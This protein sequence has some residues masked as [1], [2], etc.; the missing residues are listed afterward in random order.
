[1]SVQS[2][3]LIESNQTI[4]SLESAPSLTSFSIDEIFI[5]LSQCDGLVG[6]SLDRASLVARIE[7]S[8]RQHLLSLPSPWRSRV[9][10][11]SCLHFGA[12]RTFVSSKLSSVQRDVALV[13]YL[14]RSIHISELFGSDSRWKSLQ[15]QTMAQFEEFVGRLGGAAEVERICMAAYKRQR[16]ILFREWLIRIVP[17]LV[18]VSTV[19]VA[20]AMAFRFARSL[21]LGQ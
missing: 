6:E 5:I 20:A 18:L 13:E 21:T 7:D 1:V 19:A 11:W 4:L 16:L 2:P 8:T 3:E 9:G 10:F 12:F 14:L 17:T 15:L